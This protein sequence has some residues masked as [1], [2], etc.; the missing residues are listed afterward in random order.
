MEK[1]YD[2]DIPLAAHVK[3]IQ[4]GVLGNREADF[5]DAVARVILDAA[6]NGSHSVALKKYPIQSDIDRGFTYEV[7]AKVYQELVSKDYKLDYSGDN[8]KV[9]WNV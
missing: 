6:K 3:E 7:Y 8:L 9:S 1:K 2:K 4:L 5:R